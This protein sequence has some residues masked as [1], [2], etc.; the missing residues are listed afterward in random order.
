MTRRPSLLRV[1]STLLVLASLS[2]CGQ[3]ATPA[4]ERDTSTSYVAL[5]D[6]YTAAPGVAPSNDACQQSNTN[7]P[8]RV[9][10]RLKLDLEDV[11]CGGAR[12]AH[13]T[14]PQT[15][16]GDASREPQL[17]AVTRDTDIVTVSL[18]G[19]D[20]GILPFVGYFCTSLRAKNPSGAPCEEANASAETGPIEI[21][22]T[23]MEKRL[24]RVLRNVAKRAPRARIIV[25]GYPAVFPA[26]ATSC[27]QL[28]LA[29][30]DFVFA[31]RL[32][33]LLV[34][35]QKSAAERAKV[36][37]VDVFAAST[38]HDMCAEDPWISGLQPEPS[39]AAP[40]HPYAAEQK[41]VADLLTDLLRGDAAPTPAQPSDH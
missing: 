20:T 14:K 24:V 10:A 18:G 22:V 28:P 34:E 11:S 36:E 39:Y 25:V 9:A 7:Y 13:V 16:D 40:L 33:V 8:H 15:F 1:V 30:G 5:G 26:E 21:R 27:E 35:A 2:A 6:S 29:R 37:Y 38:G 31:H 12:T 3:R 17:R 19:S 41:L 32:N 23:V 4:E